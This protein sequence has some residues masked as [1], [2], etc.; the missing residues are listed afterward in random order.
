MSEIVK[1]DHQIGLVHQLANML[2]AMSSARICDMP[3]IEVDK[4]LMTAVHKAYNDKGQT[5][6]PDTMSYIVDNLCSSVLKACP[7]IR[8]AEIPIAIEKGILGDYGDYFGL[9]VVTFVNFVKSHYESAK[10][11]EIAKQTQVKDEGKPMPTE[12]EVL[13][14]DKKLLCKAFETFKSSGYYEDH[15]NHMYR[16]AVKKLKIFELSKDL[17]N[18]YLKLGKS[19]ALEKL[20][21]EQIQKPFD[22]RRITKEITEANELIPKSD[23]IKKVYKEALQLA[24]MDWFKNL[25]EMEVDIRELVYDKD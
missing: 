11:A 20:K 12:I 16:V 22:R 8:I 7:F 10:R 15:G 23:G 17:Q 14:A 1:R 4:V 5:V 13:E 6:D 21:N 3:E 19:R 18:E 24:L 2:E 25:L 9:N